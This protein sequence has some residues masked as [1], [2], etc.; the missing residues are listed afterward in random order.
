MIETF[1]V[2]EWRHE[3]NDTCS[4]LN[5]AAFVLGP[6]SG[7]G[8]PLINSNP[9]ATFL[10]GGAGQ[11]VM[12]TPGGGDEGSRLVT[13]PASDWLEFDWNGN[14]DESPSATITFF[15]LFSSED[16]MIDVHEVFP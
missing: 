13:Y 6:Y 9:A 14:G 11:F 7:S 3:S 4:T 1:N 16:G 12:T 10:S 8:N 5:T 15:N 2:G